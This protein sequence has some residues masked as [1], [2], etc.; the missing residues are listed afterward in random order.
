MDV[1]RE[2]RK[3]TQVKPSRKYSTANFHGKVVEGYK[4]KRLN[5]SVHER[6]AVLTFI[7]LRRIDLFRYSSTFHIICVY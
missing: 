7:D 3:R 6:C 4:S 1:V 2:K 5:E